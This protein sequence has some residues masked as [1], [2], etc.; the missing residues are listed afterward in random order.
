[1]QLCFASEIFNSNSVGN[2]NFFLIFWRSRR[3]EFVF[4]QIRATLIIGKDLEYFN[5]INRDGPTPQYGPWNS[6]GPIPFSSVAH[7]LLI[8]RGPPSSCLSA[9]ACSPDCARRRECLRLT[10]VGLPTGTH[11]FAAHPYLCRE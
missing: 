8:G 4:F 5:W 10:A 7:W 11:R 2:L 9:S 3:M 1:M 6:T